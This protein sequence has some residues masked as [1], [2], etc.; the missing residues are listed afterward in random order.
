[1]SYFEVRLVVKAIKQRDLLILV[2]FIAHEEMHTHKLYS[3]FIL[4]LHFH[5]FLD[6]FS[7]YETRNHGHTVIKSRNINK[8]FNSQNIVQIFPITL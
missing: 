5:I 6:I 7:I 3:S 8:T 2:I 4:A 1:M